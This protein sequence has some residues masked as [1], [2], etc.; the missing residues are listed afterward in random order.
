MSKGNAKQAEKGNI[1]LELDS[2]PVVMTSKMPNKWIK[3][4][5]KK[6]HLIP[7]FPP[8]SPGYWVLERQKHEL[9]MR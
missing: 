6:I 5:T 8:I 4:N 7:F 9:F 2:D 1:S 3:L